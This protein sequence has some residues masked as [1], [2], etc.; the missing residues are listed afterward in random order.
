MRWL[1]DSRPSRTALRSA[2]QLALK[3]GGRHGDAE[4]SHVPS[5]RP[6]CCLQE[7]GR[8][9]WDGCHS[10]LWG[11]VEVVIAAPLGIPDPLVINSGA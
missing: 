10:L 1:L 3:A 6:G 4:T 9:G 2:R 8:G 7:F 5:A 11:E